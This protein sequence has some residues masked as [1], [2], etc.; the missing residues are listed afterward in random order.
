MQ[1]SAENFVTP[2]NP[3]SRTITLSALDMPEKKNKQGSLLLN[4]IAEQYIPNK[5]AAISVVSE[6]A[7]RSLKLEIKPYDKTRIKAITA[8]GKE[9]K[10]I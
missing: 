10:D 3:K 2:T 1:Q 5:G 7:A 4:N 6:E 9:V 8:D